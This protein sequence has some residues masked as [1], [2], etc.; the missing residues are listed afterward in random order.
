MNTV[1]LVMLLRANRYR[2]G[3]ETLL[4]EDVRALLARHGIPHQREHVLGPADRVD[5]LVDGRIALEL[6]IKMPAR[7]VYRQLERYATHDCV[8]S[9]VLM[10]ATAISMPR[11]F[12]SK[13]V[14][15]VPLGRNGL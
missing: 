1:D 3:H 11:S 6:K 10:S 15:L 14:Y 2:L 9:L 5:F 13:P 12:N 8:D 4:Q 7:H